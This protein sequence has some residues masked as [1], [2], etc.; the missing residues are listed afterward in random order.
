MLESVRV[1]VFVCVRGVLN[2][3]PSLFPPRS[4]VCR[5][6]GGRLVTEG[7]LEGL[8]KRDMS[9]YR[10]CVPVFSSAYLK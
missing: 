3:P 9:G 10:M 5:R 1:C 6:D 8:M 4:N 2:G 7:H